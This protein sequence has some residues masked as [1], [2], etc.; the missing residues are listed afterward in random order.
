M[1][2]KNGKIVVGN[3]EWTLSNKGFEQSPDAGTFATNVAKWFTGGGAGK[4]HAYSNNF[5]LIESAL[6]E[7][8]TSAGHTW[9]TGA[10]SIKFDLPTLLSY[11][12]IFIGGNSVDNKVLVD[13]VKA[14]GNVY[15]AAGTGIGGYQGEANRLK[16][17]LNPFGLKL[18]PSS[19]GLSG[20]Q[21]ISSDHP[22]LA[23]VK[24]LYQVDGNSI[25]DI[26]PESPANS[27]LV[28]HPK[29]GGLYAVFDM[30]LTKAEVA[31]TDIFYKGTVKQT[32]SDEYIEITNQGNAAIELSGW[33]VN[34]GNDKQDFTFPD[35]TMMEPGQIYRIYTDEVHP[36]WGG[37]SFGI[38]RAIWNN[39]GDEGK[40]YDAEGKLVTSLAYGDKKSD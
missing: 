26:D 24:S 8:M 3:D 37:F 22:I 28:N 21:E 15:V 11:D 18:A 29:V 35:G 10:N 25:V 39:K 34:A 19:N 23:G 40:V 13:Y 2:Q 30:S 14:G 33:R 20:N 36:E 4:F 1:A 38:K 5:G 16:T 32:E 27:I 12:G 17:F 31:I 7:A 6:A 9:T